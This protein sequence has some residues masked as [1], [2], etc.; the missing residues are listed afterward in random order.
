MKRRGVL[1]GLGAGIAGIGGLGAWSVRAPAN[2][3]Y[4]GPVS[5]H[6]DGRIF[7]NPGGT[8]PGSLADLLKWR[9]TNRPAKWPE[10]WP[11]PFHAPQI[12][13]EVRGSRLV[14]TLVGHA[15]L[16]VQ[17]AGMNILTDP[18]WSDRASPV[19]FAGPRRVNAPG[20][21]L[22]ELPRIDIILITHNHYDHLDLA[23]LARLVARHD[24]Q[25]LTPLGNDTI[26]RQSISAAR[27]R[28]GDWGQSHLAGGDVNVRI[29]PVHHWSARGIADR[30]MALWCG[31][32]LETPSG[33]I[34]HVG[35]TGFEDGKQFTELRERHGPFRLVNMPIG[36][37]EPRWFMKSQHV[38]PD[39]AVQAVKLAG[40][41]FAIGH[42]WGTFQLTE[43]AIEAPRL[44]LEMARE[45][46][47][48][49]AGR[50]P[51]ARP[52]QS[53]EIPPLDAA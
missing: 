40:A 29:V 49:P 11:S 9:I 50:F 28:T 47:G 39:E 8:P 31:F 53:F 23:S 51:A 17:T 7:F 43:E 18:V 46:H 14:V 33:N 48:V 21:A 16:L 22:A 30:R 36:A 34:L 25:I 2:P 44:A 1:A 19:R 5:D 20:V 41:H 4:G 24:P 12:E 45:A 15:S 37:Y 26:I 13:P 38:N 27:I 52:G 10:H 35:D 32:V 6:F 3:Y 42:H